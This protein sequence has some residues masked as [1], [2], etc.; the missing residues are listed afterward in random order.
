M[1]RFFHDDPAT[2]LG[3]GAFLLLLATQLVIL[4]L[5]KLEKHR[6]GPVMLGTL[7]TPL[8]TG[9]PNLMIGLFGRE[10]LRDD[11]V[12]Q[13]NIGNNLADTTLITGLILF[14][15]GP[16]TV[17]PGKGKSKQARRWNT[18]QFLALAFLWLAAGVLFILARDGR[19]TARDGI[20]LTSIYFCYQLIAYKRRGKVPAKKRLSRPAVLLILLLLGVSAWLIQWSVTLMNHGLEQMGG[21]FPGSRLG[22]FL[23]LLTVI[24]ESFLLLRLAMQKGSLGFSGLVG[25]CFVSIPLVVGLSSIFFPFS[26][27]AVTS[28]RDTAFGPYLHL[29]VAMLAF[30][31]LSL[32]KRPIPRKIGLLFMAL[33]AI[34][35]WHAKG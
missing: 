20:V 22:L 25:D 32:T 23:G 19:L 5:N 4:V 18:D 10:Q 33:Y 6:F 29:F 11:L 2:L 21:L 24:P 26:T 28:V 16:L 34:V 3:I 27:A 14:V 35:W 30:T 1:N 9:F 13:L 8:C 12:L 15:S 7:I 17:R 31:L